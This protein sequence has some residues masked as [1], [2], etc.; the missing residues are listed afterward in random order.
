MGLY[1]LLDKLLGFIACMA[2][3]IMFGLLSSTEEGATQKDKNLI[4][5]SKA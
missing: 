3:L 2:A 1:A 5:D 4:I